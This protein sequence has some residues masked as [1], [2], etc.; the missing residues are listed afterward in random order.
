MLNVAL[1]N[2]KNGIEIRFESKPSDNVLTA[3]HE[4]GFRWSNKQKMWYAKQTDERITF[5]NSL[6]EKEGIFVPNKELNQKKKESYNLWEMTR[7]DTIED[8]FEKYHIYDTK[9][10]AAI[11]RKHLK[12]RFPMCKWSVTKDGNSIYV[13]LLVSPWKKDSDEV[14]SIVHYA[15]EFAQSYNYDNE[16]NIIDYRYEQR[17]A[18]V[19]EYNMSNDFQIKK[20]AFEKAEQERKE[21]E[22]Q[23]YMARREIEIAEGQ[24]RE[25]ESKARHNVIENG[26]EVKEVSILYLTVILLIP[27]KKIRFLIILTTVAKILK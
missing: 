19:S 23:E 27:V 3:L 12:E 10:I 20:A 21:K 15:Y 4:Y 11:I 18:T 6:A 8:N 13:H 24:K 2:A 7:T 16:D 22:F 14:N 1:N 26:A 17:E 25:E 9:E 5:A